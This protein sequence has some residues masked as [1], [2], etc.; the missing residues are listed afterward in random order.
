MLPFLPPFSLNGLLV[1]STKG[2]LTLVKLFQKKWWQLEIK[3]SD[4]ILVHY[5]L[6]GSAGRRNMPGVDCMENLYIKNITSLPV[7]MFKPYGLNSANHKSLYLSSG[8]RER[9]MWLIIE[10]LL[11]VLFWTPALAC[12]STQIKPMN[13]FSCVSY[14]F[15][16]FNVIYRTLC[17][18]PSIVYC[19]FPW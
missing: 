9:I 13:T 1:T 11:M 12:P 15:L 17:L 7:H 8:G 2:A 6:C 19:L 5:Q 3:W 10:E 16:T 18:N 14:W 4:E